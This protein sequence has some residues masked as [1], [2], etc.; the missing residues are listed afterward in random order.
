M[1][2]KY[3][4]IVVGAGH[5]GC[6][7]AAAAAN[8]GANVLLITLNMTNIAQMSCNPAMGGIAKGQVVREI[9]ALGGYSGIIADKSML[10]F[11]MLN[12]SKGPAV[13]SPRSQNDRFLFSYYWRITLENIPNISFWQD[14]VVKLIVKGTK[15]IG[16]ETSLS[17][18]FYAKAVILSNGTFLNGKIFIGQHFLYGGRIS[19]QNSVGLTEQLNALGIK[20]EK[21]K[22]GT[23]PRVDGRTINFSAMTEQKGDEPPGKFSFTDTTRLTRQKSCFITYTSEEVHDILQTGF[24]KSPLFTGTIKG[25]GPRYCPSIEDKVVRFSD[26]NRHQ[27]FLEPEGW[28]T[29]EYYVNGFSTSLPEDVQ[30]KALRK[31]KGLE[32]AKLF[33]PGYAI[34]YDY[35]PPTQ[36]S[37]TL[38]SNIIENLF[39][40]GQVNGTTGY[41]EASCQG[42]IA[43]IN[44]FNKI[45]NRSPFILKRS[46][47]Y[48]GVLIDDLVTKGTDEPYRLFT[49]RAENRMLLRQD[50]ADIRLTPLGYELGLIKKDR[51]QQVKDKIV[52]I[53]KT[54]RYFKKENLSPAEI[55]DYIITVKSTPISQKQKIYNILLRPQIN[56]AGLINNSEKLQQY[57]QNNKIIDNTE[58]LEEIEILIKYDSYIQKEEEIVKKLGKFEK[59]K[60]RENFDYKKLTSLSYEAREKLAR[61]KPK[62]LAQAASISGVS[63][64]DIAVLLTYFGKI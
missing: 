23:P 55:N 49:S 19:E 20:S 33:R 51:Y 18:M 5:A 27:L 43:G 14:N 63:P 29:I 41:E 58:I 7:A 31:I 59:I 8:L 22:T 26:K 2:N 47:A 38:E 37:Y 46:E 35:F 9:D 10:Q 42:L 21:F 48:I 17:I 28:D 4:I 62:N 64:A 44:A 53:K 15:V 16:V 52:K 36:L 40:A 25:R 54:I 24:D 13:W 6:E 11:R 57:L 3:D 34:E 45:N 30:I 61:I 1:Q 12:K 32:N 50:N 60:L 39:F 56:L